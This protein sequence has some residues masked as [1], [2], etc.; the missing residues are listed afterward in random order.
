MK[1]DP[2]SLEQ[3]IIKY[4]GTYSSVL[5]GVQSADMVLIKNHETAQEAV[6]KWVENTDNSKYLLPSLAMTDEENLV[7]TDVAT[8]I[9][10]YVGE[11]ALKFVLGEASL[12]EFDAYLAELEKMG[13]QKCLDVY[14]AAYERYLAR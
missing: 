14:N 7:I 11:M 3:A 6:Y 13:L 4:T 9:K 1:N 2:E 5:G 12:D 10:A 8:P